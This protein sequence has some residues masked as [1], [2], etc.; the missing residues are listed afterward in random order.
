MSDMFGNHSVGFPTRR[1]IC[2]KNI[3]LNKELGINKFDR[4]HGDVFIQNCK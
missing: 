2:Y 1:L 3:R 4:N